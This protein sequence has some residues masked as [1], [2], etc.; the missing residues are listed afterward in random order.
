MDG[1]YLQEYR[2]SRRSVGTLLT[3]SFPSIFPGGIM[4][5][6]CTIRVRFPRERCSER[7]CSASCCSSGPCIGCAIS[8]PG[9]EVSL[10]AGCVARGDSA[11]SVPR[12]PLSRGTWS[13]RE[14][15]TC[16]NRSGTRGWGR[17]RGSAGGAKGGTND[18]DPDGGA[19]RCWGCSVELSS[20]T[21]QS[22]QVARFRATRVPPTAS[23]LRSRRLL[24]HSYGLP[25][26]A[27]KLQR[28]RSETRSGS[29]LKRGGTCA[30]E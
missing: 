5:T 14:T 13:R 17:F 7:L 1:H 18:F 19:S 8:M 21:V 29:L 15:R 4:G 11:Q 16:P 24:R 20:R 23:Q 25:A 12:C 27:G 6:S 28:R 26:D 10:V 22:Q 30:R 2:A 9:R 3:R